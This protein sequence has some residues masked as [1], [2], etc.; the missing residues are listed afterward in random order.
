MDVLTQLDELIELHV[1]R[2]PKVKRK[3]TNRLCRDL[4]VMTLFSWSQLPQDLYTFDAWFRKTMEI[5]HNLL[6][7]LALLRVIYNTIHASAQQRALW[8]QAL[9][10]GIK[11]LSK[12]QDIY[13]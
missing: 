3:H 5:L 2:D 1:S 6:Y 11:V 4:K 13:N 12:L 10:R 8:H 9:K 7:Q